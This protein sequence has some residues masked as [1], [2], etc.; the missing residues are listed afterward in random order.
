MQLQTLDLEDFCQFTQLSLT[1]A[2][3]LNFI[4]GHNGSGKSNTM[5]AV[6]GCLT[7]DFRSRNDGTNADN[8]CQFSSGRTSAKV[9]TH[10][11]HNGTS[12]LVSRILHKEGKTTSCLEVTTDNG[13]ECYTKTSE[14]TS[15]LLSILGISPKM[16]SDYVF[17]DQWSVF[18]FLTAT[19]SERGKAF[20]RLFGTEQAEVIY[21]AAG[22]Q[23]TQLAIPS[24][25]VSLDSA[26]AEVA[27]TQQQ[28]NA[29]RAELDTF[30]DI[31]DDYDPATDPDKGILQSFER[32]E[33][34]KRESAEFEARA[35]GLVEV[36][37]KTQ[38]DHDEQAT[39]L[40]T[41]QY[42]LQEAR[43]EI[44]KAR[45][46]LEAWK[47]YTPIAA[48]V[49]RYDEEIGAARKELYRL[50]SKPEPTDGYVPLVE[51]EALQNKYNQL[52]TE[53]AHIKLKVACTKRGVCSVCGQDTKE[54]IDLLEGY[55]A[56]VD[57]DNQLAQLR[58]RIQQSETYDRMLDGWNQATERAS[59]Q[60]RNAELGL[61]RLPKVV[62]P[63]KDE[64]ALRR[65][66]QQIDQM[67]ETINDVNRQVNA[68]NSQLTKYKTEQELCYQE[69]KKRN[70]SIHDSKFLTRDAEEAKQRL[71][72]KHQRYI[73]KRELKVSLTA[74]QARLDRA[75]AVLAEIENTD[76]KANALRAWQTRLNNIRTA[77]HRDAAPRI[78]A[79][80]YLELIQYEVNELLE[81]FDSDFRVEAAEGLSFTAKF[82]RGPKTGAVQPAGRLSG[83]EKT[84]LGIAFRVAVNSMF[85]NDIGLL[86]L[87]EPTAG[88]DNE[89]LTCLNIA[90]DRLRELSHNSGLQIIMI[91]HEENLPTAD[92]VI[93]IGN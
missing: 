30:A 1:F 51:R 92:N 70:D 22:R 62:R 52:L 68:L 69:A 15:K 82:V 8:I 27:N 78:T 91:T 2:P 59:L 29:L 10:L 71:Q 48:A 17:V 12:L 88:L 34:L 54:L 72:H 31:P 75:I 83:G 19:D 90:F 77:C 40:G 67:C 86:V 80:N 21:Q 3:G 28:V 84:L 65:Y 55:D 13:Q 85:T 39:D 20:Q 49:R 74:A 38:A 26:R 66:L 45:C 24:T 87:D 35:S 60:L 53:Q 32:I 44:D 5:K 4:V 18:S 25:A 6:Y 56:I 73:T 93:E 23:L 64:T 47:T 50:G 58:G 14:V 36:I 76:L 46:Q 79:Y 42:F 7:G 16:L 61:E 63:D 81:R 41:M 11:S 43:E 9:V 89:N 57:Y 33:R 37:A